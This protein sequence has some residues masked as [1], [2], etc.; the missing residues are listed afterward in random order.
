[1]LSGKPSAKNVRPC[2]LHIL[3]LHCGGVSSCA[4]AWALRPSER[5]IESR[6]DPRRLGTVRKWQSRRLIKQ[7]R[8]TACA[9]L[10]KMRGSA[11]SFF[12]EGD[13]SLVAPW[14]AKVCAA[15]SPLS[16]KT[17]HPLDACLSG[18]ASLESVDTCRAD[19]IPNSEERMMSTKPKHFLQLLVVNQKVIHYLLYPGPLRPS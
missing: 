11:A 17:A 18:R 8:T 19:T 13:H 1:V 2:S 15:K 16:A 4:G 14:L 6:S 9:C 10:H 7:V 5:G 12:S 3:A